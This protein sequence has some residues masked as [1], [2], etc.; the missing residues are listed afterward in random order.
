MAFSILRFLGLRKKRPTP[1]EE[2]IAEPNK[3]T[4]SDADPIGNDPDDGLGG[5]GGGE[6]DGGGDGE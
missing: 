4:A 3:P 2:K 1:A 5:E 6:G